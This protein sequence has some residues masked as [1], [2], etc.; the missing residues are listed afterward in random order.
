ML[1]IK[2]PFMWKQFFKFDKHYQIC[3]DAN[4]LILL[5]VSLNLVTV[6]CPTALKEKFFKDHLYQNLL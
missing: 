3:S 4:L 6:Q 2:I 5:T 1:Y